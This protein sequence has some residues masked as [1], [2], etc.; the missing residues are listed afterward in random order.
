MKSAGPGFFDKVT[1]TYKRAVGAAAAAG[2]AG[3]AA[4]WGPTL[5]SS[6]PRNITGL[7]GYAGYLATAKEKFLQHKHLVNELGEA[8]RYIYAVEKWVAATPGKFCQENLRRILADAK[9]HVNELLHQPSG[10]FIAGIGKYDAELAAMI[11]EGHEAVDG[12]RDSYDRW[13]KNLFQWATD[14]W[15]SDYYRADLAAHMIKL[16]EAV[17]SGIMA[18]LVEDKTC[19]PPPRLSSVRL[20]P[21]LQFNFDTLLQ[22]VEE[23][24]R[25]SPSSDLSYLS[26][27]MLDVDAE[28]P[29]SP[30]KIRAKLSKR[31]RPSNPSAGGVKRVRRSRTPRKRSLKRSRSRTQK[32]KKTR[33]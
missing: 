19:P 12:N 1:H 3:A 31:A 13:I 30:P 20:D 18:M 22:K 17:E 11:R 32:N 29:R 2:V 7:A 6:I 8:Q 25:D 24:E 27:P 28:S 5:M 26:T 14:Y 33:K 15:W 9:S 16:I 4:W 10:H 23:R 21:E